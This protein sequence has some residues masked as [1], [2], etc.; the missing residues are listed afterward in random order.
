MTYARV[1]PTQFQRTRSF[2][3][4]LPLQRLAVIIIYFSILVE[5]N[6]VELVAKISIIESKFNS[7]HWHGIFESFWTKLWAP[8]DLFKCKCRR[9]IL[10]FHAHQSIHV[11]KVWHLHVSVSTSIFFHVFSS[12]SF[13][14]H[15]LRNVYFVRFLLEVLQH[16]CAVGSCAYFITRWLCAWFIGVNSL[17]RFVLKLDYQLKW[18]FC[19]WF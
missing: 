4:Y 14:L 13:F 9:W 3:L 2:P 12:V 17:I 19:Q 15:R 7:I 18:L 10:R 1:Q 16:A 8:D 6:C 11:R 5:I